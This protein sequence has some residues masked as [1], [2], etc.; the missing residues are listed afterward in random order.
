MLALSWKTFVTVSRLC[1][2]WLDVTGRGKSW[3][4][5]DQWMNRYTD[6]VPKNMLQFGW[7]NVCS[8]WK[9]QIQNKFPH[10][11]NN[12]TESIGS[13]QCNTHL[14]FLWNIHH[15]TMVIMK[16]NI[17]FNTLD[18]NLVLFRS[19]GWLWLWLPLSQVESVAVVLCLRPESSSSLLD[20]WEGTSRPLSLCLEQYQREK[21]VF[22]WFLFPL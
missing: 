17:L 22:W 9:S 5:A 20:G 6:T 18:L 2:I 12:S 11:M 14:M 10:F 3:R 21:C 15:I 4:P 8:V 13:G 1:A 7:P 19:S 16:G